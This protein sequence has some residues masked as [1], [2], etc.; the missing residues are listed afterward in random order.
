[1]IKIADVMMK[2]NPIQ[3]GKQII[4]S[5]EIGV[6]GN[7]KAKYTWGSI[8]QAFT[9]ETLWLRAES[10]RIKTGNWSKIRKLY[11]WRS[12][13]NSGLTWEDLRRGD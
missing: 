11:T 13:K 9:W 5:V 1:M 12:L 2:P 4:V 10:N 7:L 6:W 8:K 3:T